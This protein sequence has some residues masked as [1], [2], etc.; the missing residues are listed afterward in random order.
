MSTVN[1]ASQVNLIYG[2]PGTGKSRIVRKLAEEKGSYVFS[3]ADTIIPEFCNKTQISE[4]YALLSGTEISEEIVSILDGKTLPS[5]AANCADTVLLQFCYEIAQIFN[6]EE[7]FS[8]LIF[9]GVPATFDNAVLSNLV[10][11]IRYLNNSGYT[12]Y[13]VTSKP[14]RVKMFEETFGHTLNMITT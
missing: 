14:E 9:D 2:R 7:P 11:F 12:I 10:E 1:T 13:F 6:M 5:T 8:T 3:Y 4:L